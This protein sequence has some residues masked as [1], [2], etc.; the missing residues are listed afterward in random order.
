MEM[1]ARQHKYGKIHLAKATAHPR[2]FMSMCSCEGSGG[3]GSLIV[4][5]DHG[6]F[7]REGSLEPAD[8]DSCKKCLRLQKQEDAQ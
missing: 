2:C 5:E 3:G 1:T 4:Y 8:P 6:G 7:I